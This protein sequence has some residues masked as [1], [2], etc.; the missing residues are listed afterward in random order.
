MSVS[1]SACI[2][3]FCANGPAA[4]PQVLSL[5]PGVLSGAAPCLSGADPCGVCEG[6]GSFCAG[7]DGRPNSGAALDRCGVCG[8]ANACVGCDNVVGSN[9]T[10]DACGVCGGSNACKTSIPLDSHVPGAWPSVS[11]NLSVVGLGL[12]AE[13]LDVTARAKIKGALADAVH[14]QPASVDLVSLDDI[15][16]QSRRLGRDGFLGSDVNHDPE[17]YG[18]TMVDLQ[19][20]NPKGLLAGYLR[21]FIGAESE[22][23]AWLPAGRAHV[24]DAN[25]AAWSGCRVGTGAFWPPDQ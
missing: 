13:K 16:V 5:G 2:S 24:C 17:N 10:V 18:H 11:V 19:A 22:H 4:L 14:I 12:P 9:A 20:A 8:G 1:A 15:V 21:G 6:D 7:C 23:P 25:R 3:P